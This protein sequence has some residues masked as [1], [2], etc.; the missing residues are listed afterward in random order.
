MLFSKILLTISL[1]ILPGWDVV[2][3]PLVYLVLS[4]VRPLLSILLVCALVRHSS[5]I[6][7]QNNQTMDLRH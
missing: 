5:N 1:K 6:L 4:N 7:F 2:F 3:L